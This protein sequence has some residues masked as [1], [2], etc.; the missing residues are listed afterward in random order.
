[1]DRVILNTQGSRFE[2]LAFDLPDEAPILRDLL[3]KLGLS[4]IELHHFVGLPAA[5]LELV[6]NLGVRYDVYVHDYS[7]VCPRVN[8]VGGNNL[9]CGEPAIEDC[10]TC[11]RTHGT[12]LEESL[13]VAALRARSAWILEGASDVIA[14]TEDVR[15]RLARYF[16]TRPVKITGWE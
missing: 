14:P 9:Y 1:M 13:T 3:S 7:W 2:N 11:I 5:T 4:R 16:P 15:G 8:L 6:T 10:E 12:E